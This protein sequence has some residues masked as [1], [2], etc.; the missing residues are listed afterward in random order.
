MTRRL[1]T[2]PAD[3]TL[4]AGESHSLIRFV[5][6]WRAG[7]DDDGASASIRPDTWAGHALITQEPA[8][9]RGS[10]DVTVDSVHSHWSQSPHIL[11]RLRE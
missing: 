5:P 4:A 1:A 11:V 9:G 7:L 10:R 6:H 3:V 8:L 2:H